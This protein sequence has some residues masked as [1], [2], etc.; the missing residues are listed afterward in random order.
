MAGILV[1]GTS[2]AYRTQAGDTPQSVAANLASMARVNSIVHLS[3]ST[4]TIA[5]AGNL[6][7]RVV[8]NAFV[9]Q[10]VRRQEQGFRVT[11]WCPTPA[12]RDAV[13][14]AVNQALSTNVSSHCR[15]G[16]AAD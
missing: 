14:T 13:A 2:Y 12:A 9:Q 4:L 3:N 16:L 1:D 7:A 15:M 5:G 8:A 6:L 10:E 11:C